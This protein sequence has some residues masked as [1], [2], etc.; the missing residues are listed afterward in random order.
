MLYFPQRVSCI[1][2]CHHA[3]VT[4]YDSARGTAPWLHWQLFIA[5]TETKQSDWFTLFFPGY[6]TTSLCTSISFWLLTCRNSLQKCLDFRW[7]IMWTL[8]YVLQLY[9]ICILYMFYLYIHSIYI[10]IFNSCNMLFSG[11]DLGRVHPTMQS[12]CRGS[13]VAGTGIPMTPQMPPSPSAWMSPS[14]VEEK[15]HLEAW[16]SNHVSHCLQ[17]SIHTRSFRYLF[18]VWLVKLFFFGG[19]EIVCWMMD[20]FSVLKPQTSSS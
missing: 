5:A 15:E 8:V 19:G 18:F 2:C 17:L 14:Q 3:D 13:F 16:R 4:R 12:K 20:G 10:H 1:V 7:L 9:C 11:S 6:H